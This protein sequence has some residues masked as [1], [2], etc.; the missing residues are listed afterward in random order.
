MAFLTTLRVLSHH[1]PSSPRAPLV[2]QKK[3]GLSWHDGHRNVCRYFTLFGKES[4]YCISVIK[5]LY[6]KYHRD[7]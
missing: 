7:R 3:K 5:N 6:F 2:V 4:A 1:N